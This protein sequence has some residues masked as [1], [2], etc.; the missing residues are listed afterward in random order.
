MKQES[1]EGQGYWNARDNRW[2][3]DLSHPYHC[4]THVT[5]LHGLSMADKIVS[6]WLVKSVQWTLARST[7]FQSLP[8]P[9]SNNYCKVEKGAYLKQLDLEFLPMVWSLDW[10]HQQQ[11]LEKY[12][13]YKALSSTQNLLSQKL[14]SW[15]C[16]LWKVLLKS[17][18]GD[19]NVHWPQMF[20]NNRLT[21]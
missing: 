12:Y 11:H 15:G 16:H 10:Q 5:P 14:W 20:K 4:D 19:S 21:A 2:P 7:E 9:P 1:V 18:P 6:L 8:F 13:K 3:G 17:T